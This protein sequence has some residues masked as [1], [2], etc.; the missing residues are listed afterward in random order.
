MAAKK[1]SDG[2]P[3]R[4]P[5]RYLEKR[6]RCFFWEFR[7]AAKVEVL[8]LFSFAGNWALRDCRQ[9]RREA[10]RREVQAHAE[11]AEDSLRDEGQLHC[12]GAGDSEVVGGK[13]GHE[14]SG[15]EE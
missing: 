10:E 11:P 8:T 12:S 7:W 1:A 13:S 3:L 4:Y 9:K 6:L 5:A 15:R 14:E 2:M